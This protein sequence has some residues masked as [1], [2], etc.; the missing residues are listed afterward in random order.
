MGVGNNGWFRRRRRENPHLKRMMTGGTHLGHHPK[1]RWDVLGVPHGFFL[2]PRSWP[3]SSQGTHLP[4]RGWVW[5]R[6]LVI[7]FMIFLDDSMILSIR[8]EDADLLDLHVQEGDLLV[9]GLQ[10]QF[11]AER[12]RSI[13]QALNGGL[14]SL[15]FSMHHEPLTSRYKIV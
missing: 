10:P 1:W 12:L 14:T 2:G 11:G 8:A 4:N 5:D 3:I 6:D 13:Q 15:V 9:L 7:F